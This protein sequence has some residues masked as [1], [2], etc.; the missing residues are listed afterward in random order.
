VFDKIRTVE[1]GAIV[2]NMRLSAVLEHVKAQQT[3]YA[4]HQQRGHG[5]VSARGPAL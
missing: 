3:A 4:P 2:E 5:R 1:P